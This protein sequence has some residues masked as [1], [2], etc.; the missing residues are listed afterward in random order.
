MAYCWKNLYS[1]REIHV[2]IQESEFPFDSLQNTPA[3]LVT[4][5]EYNTKTI[6]IWLP[7]PDQDQHA[8]SQALHRVTSTREA[9]YFAGYQY[10]LT[11]WSL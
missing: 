5:T 4:T 8:M 6:T 3:L 9:P 7:S 1:E 2:H 11:Q 10:V